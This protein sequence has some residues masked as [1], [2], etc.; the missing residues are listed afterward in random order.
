MF[1]DLKI[2]VVT[3]SPPYEQKTTKLP[4]E[5]LKIARAKT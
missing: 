5:K 3:V 1:F 2:D 4:L